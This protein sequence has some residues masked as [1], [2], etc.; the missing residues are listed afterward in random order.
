M[1]REEFLFS[2]PRKMVG[3]KN[4]GG[5][6]TN[7]PLKVNTAGVIP[8]IFA[9]SIMSDTGCHCTVFLAKEMEQESEEDLRGLNQ[10]T[11]VIRNSQIYIS[12]GLVV[13]I[14]FVFSLH[15]S[16]H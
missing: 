4:V 10:I 6:S 1:Q 3:K 2:I 13:Y 14:V 11:G 8:V 12:W 16:I 5:Q 7:I 9:S 15:I